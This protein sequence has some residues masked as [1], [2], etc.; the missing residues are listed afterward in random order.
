MKLTE[1]KDGVL[2][3]VYV[4]PNQP[5][6]KIEVERDDIVI[7]SSEEPV[8]GKVNKELIK[9]FSKL[10][11]TQVDLVSGSTSR[12]K[13]LLIRNMKSEQAEQQLLNV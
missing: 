3:E 5:K 13:Q 7:F 4:K 8:R 11:H 9:E 6:F 2:I 1:T 12:K 10:F